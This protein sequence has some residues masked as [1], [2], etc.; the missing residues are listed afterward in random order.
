MEERRF[1]RVLS[2]CRV[3]AKLLSTVVNYRLLCVPS[4]NG[5]FFVCLHWH[6]AT[7]FG[8]SSL[9]SIGVKSVALCEPSQNGW[10]F[11]CPHR[12]HQY[13]PAASSNTAGFL[14]A[15]TGSLMIFLRFSP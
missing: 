3:L 6:N 10:F 9:N 14:S 8:W 1:E 13:V 5:E 11:D 12:H 2:R 15:M 4:Q 7:R